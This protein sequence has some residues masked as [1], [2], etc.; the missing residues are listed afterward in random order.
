MKKDYHIV[1][2]SGGKDSTALLLRMIDESMAIDEVIFFDTGLEFPLMY[3]H[4]NK[5]KTV[6]EEHN[7]KFS[8]VKPVFSFEYYLLE[9]ERIGKDNIPRSG[10][11]WP[12]MRGRWCTAFLKTRNIEKYIADLSK[13]YNVIQ[14]LG[15]AADEKKRLERPA[16]QKGL[17][18]YPLVNWGMSEKDCL[19]FCYDRGYDWGGLYEI[20][21]RVSCWCCPLQPRTEL[22]KLWDNFPELWAKL[23]EWENKLESNAGDQAPV[24]SRPYTVKDLEKRFI[25]EKERKQRGLSVKSKNFYREVD[26]SINGISK[27]QTKLEVF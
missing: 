13:K 17:Y 8:I 26:L 5:I 25:I 21:N 2:F 24:Y 3:D 20:F 12:S 23:I 22:Y 10:W 15:I 7:L 18:K 19:K 1:S 6:V 16:H 14:Y 11:G 9:I 27:K 4:V